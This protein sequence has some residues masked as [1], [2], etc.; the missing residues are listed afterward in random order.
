[1]AT[2]QS[3]ISGGISQSMAHHR[4]GIS[5][6][7]FSVGIVKYEKIDGEDRKMLVIQFDDEKM[8]T[9]VFDLEKLK[10]ENIG[11][12]IDANSWRGDQFAEDFSKIIK[13]SAIHV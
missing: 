4:N 2:Q 6:H 11:F 13:E 10:N 3:K 5:G 9:A 12:G 7:P 1:M 8:S